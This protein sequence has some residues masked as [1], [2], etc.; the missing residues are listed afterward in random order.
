MSEIEGSQQ[1]EPELE[2]IGQLTDDP[3]E[4]KAKTVSSFGWA[5]IQQIFG[6][7]MS[8]GVNLALARLLIPEDFGIIAGD[9]YDHSYSASGCWLR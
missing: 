4:L 6:R 9:L 5:T 7:A 1:Q 8:F 2:A 3:H